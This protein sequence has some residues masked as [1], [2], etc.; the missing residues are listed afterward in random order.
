MITVRTAAERPDLWKIGSDAPPV[1]PEYNRHG[2][3]SNQ[4]WGLLVLVD[5]SAQSPDPSGP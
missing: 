5:R 4:R 3:V 2:E 1:W